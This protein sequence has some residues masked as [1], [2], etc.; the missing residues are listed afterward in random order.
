MHNHH[1]WRLFLSLA[2]TQSFTKTAA[3]LGLARSS[4]SQ[5][6]S[7]LEQKLGV[8]LFHRTTR[9]VTLTQAGEQLFD[10]LLPLFAQMDSKINEILNK[11]N[12]LQGILR[13]NGTPNSFALL[14]DKL[15][16]F[17]RQNPKICLELSA[18]FRFV[19]IVKEKFDAGIRTGDVLGQEMVAVKISEQTT[20][21]CVASPAYFTH[22]PIPQMPED[23][24][25]HNCI[26]FRLPTH[27]GLLNWSFL[28]PDTQ[29]VISQTVGGQWI[30]NDTQMLI[31]SALDGV[32]LVWI[33]RS[34]VREYLDNGRLISVLDKWAMIYS[35]DYLY[36]PHRQISPSLR[37]LVDF[38]RV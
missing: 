38:L 1:D 20:M 32:G 26:R 18:D 30:F 13:I 17:G 5:A 21:C 16:A 23:L 9:Q 3:Q 6:I 27:G 12:E 15:C 28:S 14:W 4:V 11:N 24:K 33:E 29:E 10:E 37:A 25:H 2:H 22:Y 7:T 31:S 36:Y 8:R 19:D 34:L 35:P